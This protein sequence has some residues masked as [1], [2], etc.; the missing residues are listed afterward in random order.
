ML[1]LTN[2]DPTRW[3]VA[4]LANA[5]KVALSHSAY[6]SVP[7]LLADARLKAVDRLARRAGIGV[8]SEQEYLA[9]AE[10]IRGET[11]DEMARIVQ[12]AARV[13]ATQSRVQAALAGWPSGA[14]VRRDVEEQLGNLTFNNFISATPDPWFDRIPA[15]VEAMEVRLESAR[16][17]P[18]R[19]AQLHGQVDDIESDYAD[20]VASEPPGELRLEVEEIAF[21]LEEFRVS[22]F[23]QRLRTAVPVSAK[24]LRQSI[25]SV[26]GSHGPRTG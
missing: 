13:L 17:N 4:H 26:R 14:P 12:T 5:D 23:A 25:Y 8:R 18:V 6:P 2:P 15:Y 22:L 3:V 7:A 11:A 24:R 16:I 20:L 9:L 19:D 1:T 21:L 10:A